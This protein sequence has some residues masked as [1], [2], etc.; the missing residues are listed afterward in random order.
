MFRSIAQRLS[1]WLY[2]R[3]NGIDPANVQHLRADLRFRLAM[4]EYAYFGRSGR[5]VA[6]CLAEVKSLL[7][8]RDLHRYLRSLDT[9]LRTQFVE[10]FQGMQAERGRADAGSANSGA[11]ARGRLDAAD[12][13]MVLTHL[14]QARALAPNVVPI[15]SAVRRHNTAPAGPGGQ[16][17]SG[18]S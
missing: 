9:D 5:R 4:V 12:T 6:R 18:S 11:A 3:R 13:R 2:Q 7:D 1:G 15:E 10:R 14:G 16:E 17:E 8:D